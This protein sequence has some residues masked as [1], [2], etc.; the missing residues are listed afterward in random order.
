MGGASLAAADARLDPPEPDD[1]ERHRRG[2]YIGSNK[3]VSKLE[4][5]LDG[6]MY[7]RTD[8]G[9]VDV[10]L[11]GGMASSAFPPLYYVEGLQA[12]ALFYVSQA[13]GLMGANTYCAGTG[14][15]GRRPRSGRAFRAIRRGEADVAFAGGFDDATSW[16]NM[17]QVRRHGL[18]DR[19]NDLGA[20]ACRPYDSR[21]QPDRARA[22]ERRFWSSRTEAARA[23]GA[24]S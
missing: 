23:R 24:R 13:H 22:R 5:I 19:P 7:A 6:V 8:D 9:A 10:G 21:P 15:R 11:L 14:R 1:R 3:E 4:P 20:D 2:L 17:T 18:P 12:A 16:W